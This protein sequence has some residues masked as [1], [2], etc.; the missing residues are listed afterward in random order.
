MKKSKLFMAG[1]LALL[2][3]LGLVLAGCGDDGDGNNNQQQGNNNNN[4]KNNDKDNEKNNDNNKKN[5]DN[6]KNGD[7]IGGNGKPSSAP[8][9]VTAERN[10]AG[11]ALVK[12]SWNAVSD[13]SGYYVYYS[14]SGGSD[15]GN[16]ETTTDGTSFFSSGK[17]KDKKHYFRVSAVNG[18][19]E[20]PS[21]SWVEVGLGWD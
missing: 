18:D 11:S 9:G 19:G 6:E 14:P 1:V 13:A 3:V 16:R 5:D 8:T 17:S 21:S 12:V 7:L 2:L 20:G 15:S 10:P 4:E